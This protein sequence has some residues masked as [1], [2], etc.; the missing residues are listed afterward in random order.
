MDICISCFFSNF[1]SIQ[2]AWRLED[3]GF[4]YRSYEQLMEHWRKALSLRIHEVSYEQLVTD[5]ETV[6][7]E[8]IDFC[9]LDWSDR[10]LEF[11]KNKR[12]VQT[13]SRVQVR[14]PIYNTSIGRWEKYASHLSPLREALDELGI[15]EDKPSADRTP[16]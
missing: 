1:N 13:A 11:Y 10:C 15:A 5:H 2:W 3:I 7:R 4:F 14:Q 8:M 16:S 12:P 9:G 6:S